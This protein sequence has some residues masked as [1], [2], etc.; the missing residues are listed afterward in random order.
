[1]TQGKKLSDDCVTQTDMLANAVTQLSERTQHSIDASRLIAVA[2]QQQSTVAEAIN[3]SMHQ[4]SE[5]AANNHEV[6]QTCQH[7][8]KHLHRTGH[9]FGLL[10]NYFWRKLSVVAM[11]HS[12][13]HRRQ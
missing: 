12:S 11:P 6:S 5:L 7:H 13:T 8:A 3:Y 9:D 1:M 4:I 10:T 2:V